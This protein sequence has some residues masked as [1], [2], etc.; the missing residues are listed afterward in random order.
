M[1]TTTPLDC[2]GV[3]SAV[4]ECWPNWMNIGIPIVSVAVWLTVLIIIFA[5]WPA[6]HQ[7]YPERKSHA[8]SQHVNGKVSH[9]I[10]LDEDLTQM[11]AV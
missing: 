10:R 11:T 1:D 3:D 5:T 4:A 2:D 9:K 8:S 7:P 6:T